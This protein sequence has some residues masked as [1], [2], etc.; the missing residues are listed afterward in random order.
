MAIQI[1]PPTVDSLQAL[2]VGLT[3]IR[4]HPQFEPLARLLQQV[5]DAPEDHMPHEI[6]TVDLKELAS[7]TGLQTA[8]V[9]GHRYLTRASDKDFAVEVQQVGRDGR[10]QFAEVTH[11]RI[12]D[13]MKQVLDD[14]D[15]QRLMG[16]VSFTVLMLRINTLGLHALWFRPVEDSNADLI[17]CVRPT[18]P[19]LEPWPKTYT[20]EEFAEVVKDEAQRK[21]TADRS[22]YV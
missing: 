4:T 18:P 12:V 3:K 14:P 8:R 5:H 19:Y 6:A 7:G 9:I 20:R 13:N 17:A 10:H 11:G 16:A 21:L 15:L 22:N 1:K 2:Q